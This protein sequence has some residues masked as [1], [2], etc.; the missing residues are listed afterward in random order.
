MVLSQS[1]YFTKSQHTPLCS[2]SFFVCFVL[3]FFLLTSHYI[4]KSLYLFLHLSPGG[5]S[6][7][8]TLGSVGCPPLP[9][10]AVITLPPRYFTPT[11]VGG[12]VNES[13][14]PDFIL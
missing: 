10:A 3:V 14:V 11:A 4:V 8:V 6:A 13:N 5:S 12:A 2:P 9:L 1:P 7:T